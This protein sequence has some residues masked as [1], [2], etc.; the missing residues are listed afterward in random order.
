MIVCGVVPGRERAGRVVEVGPLEQELGG[1]VG[2]RLGTVA[3]HELELREVPADLVDQH[4]LLAR[5]RHPRSA[6]AG[7]HADRDVELDAL[8]VQRIELLVVDRH[9]GHAAGGERGGRLD[10]QRLVGLHQVAHAV[11]AL[12]RVDVQRRD[13]PVG[14]PAHR[15][16]VALAAVAG[17]VTEAHADHR[18]LDAVAVHQVERGVDRVGRPEVHVGDVLEH[19]LGR[20]LVVLRL[21]AQLRLEELVPVLLVAGRDAEHQIDDPDVGGHAHDENCNRF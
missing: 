3:H 5:R 4:R 14:V 11:H 6:D 20:E 13:E 17:R 1:H 15:T 10:A 2:P 7:A 18:L 12:V 19:V 9:L 8:R 16:H 21:L